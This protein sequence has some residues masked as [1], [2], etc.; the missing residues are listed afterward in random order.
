MDRSATSDRPGSSGLPDLVVGKKIFALPY[1]GFVLVLAVT[2]GSL[3]RFDGGPIPAVRD[4]GDLF[5]LAWIAALVLDNF[6]LSLGGCCNRGW[7]LESLSRLRLFAFV[8][9]SPWLLAYVVRLGQRSE[10]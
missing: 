1:L 7:L 2:A 5:L 3:V 6:V 8:A 10:V 9:T 4:S